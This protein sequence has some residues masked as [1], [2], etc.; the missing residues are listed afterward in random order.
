MRSLKPLLSAKFKKIFEGVD[1]VKI[2]L[3]IAHWKYYLAYFQEIPLVPKN[4]NIGPSKRST[5]QDVFCVYRLA[6]KEGRKVNFEVFIAI[7]PCAMVQIWYNNSQ[8]CMV[9]AL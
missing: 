2:E 1:D 6:E 4:D 7:S 3:K 5:S 9:L 8:K